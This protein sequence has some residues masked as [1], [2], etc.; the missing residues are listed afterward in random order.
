VFQIFGFIIGMLL[1]FFKRVAKFL[2][3]AFHRLRYIFFLMLLVVLASGFVFI[4]AAPSY[5][6]PPK[7]SAFNNGWD[8]LSAFYSLASR[9]AA[10]KASYISID[11]LG[12]LGNETTLVIVSPERPYNAKERLA[13]RE[14]VANGGTLILC[15][16]NGYGADLAQEFKIKYGNSTVVDYLSYSRRQDFP[17]IPFSVG[18]ET[19]ISYSK[20]PTVLLNY[21]H[22]AVVLA[23]TSPESYLDVNKN[24]AVDEGDL[25]GPFVIAAA[26]DYGN[27]RVIAISDANIFTNDMITRGDNIIFGDAILAEYATDLIVFDE[28]HRFGERDYTLLYLF[29]YRE[30]MADVAYMALT[31]A[32]VA[33]ILLI[34]HKILTRAEKKKIE[35]QRDLKLHTYRDLVFDIAANAKLRAEPYTW[36]V[37]MQYDRFRDRLLRSIDPFRKPLENKELAKKIAKKYNLDESDLAG[38]LD[39]LES[40]KSGESSVASIEEATALCRVMEDYLHK[41]M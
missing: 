38:L 4:L 1:E 9:H 11:E 35:A 37:L 13:L 15:D 28:T 6:T 40:I 20:F 27:G 7:Y 41:I 34:A 30:K 3:H 17:L 39:R 31:I 16:T 5:L 36:I 18:R 12:T 25:K 21:P 22:D 23:S 32:V 8:G 2:L 10:T 19:G 26:V 14:F 33:I 24:L 29:A